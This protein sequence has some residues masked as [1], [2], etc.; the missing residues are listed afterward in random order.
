MCTVHVYKPTVRPVAGHSLFLDIQVVTILLKEF[1]CLQVQISA[2]PL[3]G[4]A[5]IFQQYMQHTY[6]CIHVRWDVGEAINGL[7]CIIFR[8][9]V[10]FS[11]V[12]F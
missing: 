9:P 3:P 2:T 4:H 8:L 1:T 11:S 7:I 12:E 6:M 10:S 5:R